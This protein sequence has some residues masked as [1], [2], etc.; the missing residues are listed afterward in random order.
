MKP[1]ILGRSGLAV[2]PLS[3]GAMTLGDHGANAAVIS[4]GIAH[5]LDGALPAFRPF[6]V[7]HTA[8]LVPDVAGFAIWSGCSPLP[9]AACSPECSRAVPSR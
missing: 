6:P 7:L 3:L 9:A 2:S 5:A 8:D 4:A 1:I